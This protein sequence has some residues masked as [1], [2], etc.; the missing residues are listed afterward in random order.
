MIPA[1][2]DKAEQMESEFVKQ[3]A[4]LGDHGTRVFLSKMDDMVE[5]Y[6]HMS[7]IYSGNEQ[8]YLVVDDQ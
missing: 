3:L 8:I 1:L 4:S 5:I 7:E 6:N 2:T